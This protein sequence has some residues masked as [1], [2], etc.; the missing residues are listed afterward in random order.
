MSVA[1]GAASCPPRLRFGLVGL[2]RGISPLLRDSLAL[3]LPLGYDFDWG[4]GPNS[5]GAPPALPAL[6]LPASDCAA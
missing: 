1:D 3:V 4:A 5:H 2:F 6:E